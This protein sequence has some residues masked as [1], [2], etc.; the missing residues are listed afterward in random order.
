[1]ITMATTGPRNS[2][3]E[4]SR[5]RAPV[6]DDEFVLN[7]HVGDDRQEPAAVLWFRADDLATAIAT[8]RRH[9]AAHG[10]KPGRYG[11]LYLRGSGDLLTTLDLGDGEHDDL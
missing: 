4:S 10:G 7:I 1:M 3:T 5:L 11:Q 8:S 2:G 6:G 9:L